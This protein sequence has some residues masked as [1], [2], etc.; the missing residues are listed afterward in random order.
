MALHSLP[1]RRRDAIACAA[2]LVC[3]ASAF[4]AERYPSRPIRFVVGFLP[5]GPSDTLA[6]VVGAKLAEQMGQTV[7]VDN[8][9]GAGGNV[10]AEIVSLAQPDG[11]TLLLGTGGPFVIVPITAQKVRFDP[12]RDFA[13]VTKLGDSMSLL[14]VHPST[15]FNHWKDL[16]AAAKAKPGEINYGSSGVGTIHHLAG[17]LLSSMTGIKMNHVPYKGSGAV[18]PAI[19]SGEVRVAF[20]PILPAIP[21][22]KAGRVKALGVGG[23]QRSGAAPDIPTLAE[24]GLPGF[25]ASSWYGVFVPA[26][27]PKD[28]V[29]RLHKELTSALAAAEVR[30]RLSRDGVDPDSSTPEQLAARVQLERT[31]WSRVIKQANLKIN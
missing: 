30:E 6:R 3:A 17:E 16:V 19:L 25:E 5:G 13:P 27:T 22:V 4:G 1:A 24:Q 31:T 28:I 2:L 7:I 26:K 12:D 9:A 23:A 8:R 11:H 29:A 21:H 18:L 10:S 15:G 14:E 20:G